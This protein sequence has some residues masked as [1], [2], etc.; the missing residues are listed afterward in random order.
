MQ[1]AP[2]RIIW[3]VA[4]GLVG[5]TLGTLAG[6]GRT[7]HSTEGGTTNAAAG[8]PT[9]NRDVAPI[10]FAKCA[11]CHRPGE[12]APFSLLTYDDVRRRA[13]QIVEVTQM[14]FMPPWPPD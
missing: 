6:C 12:A 13:S 11:S 5:A 1:R 4:I 7:S 8:T 2:R 14:R 9:F 3:L 10:I